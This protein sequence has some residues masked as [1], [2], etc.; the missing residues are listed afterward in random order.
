MIQTQ[1]N[2]QGKLDQD[3]RGLEIKEPNQVKH[4]TY[5]STW[6]LFI[7]PKLNNKISILHP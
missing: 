4:A 1:I 2:I 3:Y 7:T 6:Y 5:L